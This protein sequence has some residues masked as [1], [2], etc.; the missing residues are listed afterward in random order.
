MRSRQGLDAALN[1][2]NVV[3]DIFCAREPDNR[4][5]DGECVTSPMVNLAR[6]QDLA[7]LGFLAVG[8]IDR[9]TTDSYHAPHRI[10]TRGS[11]TRAPAQFAARAPNTKLDLLRALS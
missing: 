8:G 7:R 5:D 1:R 10:N 9:N 4:L 3:V 6:K 2:P 11:S